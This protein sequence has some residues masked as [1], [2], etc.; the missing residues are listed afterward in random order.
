VALGVGAVLAASG[1]S[2]GSD[3]VDASAGGSYG[4]VQQAPGQEFVPVGDRKAA[5]VLRGETLEGPTLDL[6]TFQG[7]IVVV[8][9]WA[10]WC[11]PCRAEMPHLVDLAKQ[12]PDVAF[13]GVN[14]K[15]S[16][17]AAQAFV[18]N[19]EVTY[20]SLIDRIGTLAAR[21][22][23]PPGLPSTFVLDQ[24]GQLAARFTGGVLG[25]ELGPVLDQLA[26]EP[27]R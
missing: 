2:A 26:S 6:Y 24:R 20:P 21:W 4:F 27:G 13:V 9:F 7:K 23:V 14:E 3:A 25:D 1:C 11:A 15:D 5:P 16:E 19:A 17:S 22:P 10:S 18:R 8:N 12:H